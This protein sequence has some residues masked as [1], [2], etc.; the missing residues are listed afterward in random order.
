[1]RNLFSISLFLILPFAIVSQNDEL[2]KVKSVLEKQAIAWNNGNIIEYMQGYWKNDSLK[3]IGKKG[4]TYGWENTL[5]NYQKGY[6]DKATMGI[7]SFDLL[8]VELLSAEI[9][10]VVG[11]WNLKREKDSV[12]GIF[13]L[14]LKK[15]NGEWK[16][17]S[18][19]TQ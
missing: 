17:L 1:M 5:K 4:I 11:K 14:I 3:F 15:I 19:H 9:A 18:D 6:P 7:L 2:L 13:T 10:Q 12:G 16:I 8:S